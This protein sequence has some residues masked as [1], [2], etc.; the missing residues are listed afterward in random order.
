VTSPKLR[1]RGRRPAAA[2]GAVLASAAVAVACAGPAPVPARVLSNYE[3]ATGAAIIRDCGYSSPLPGQPGSSLWLFCDTETDRDGKITGLILGRDTAAAGPYQPGRVPV[4]LSEVPTPPAPAA[5]PGA[6]APQPFLPAPS[7]LLAPDGIQPCAG[8]GRYPA[9]WISGVAPAPADGGPAGLLITYDDYCVTRHPG[10]LTPEGFGLVE[11]DPRAN[12]LGP[13][14]LVFSSL[15]GQPLPPQ[16]V[17]GSP[18]VAG[19]Y[20]YLFGFCPVASLAAGCGSVLLVRVADQPA[21]WTNPF[22]YQYWTGQDWSLDQ[23]AAGPLFPAGSPLGITVGDY[24]AVG[25]GLVLVEQTSLAGDFQAWQASS[26]AGPWRRILAG[27]VPCRQGA[28]R[29]TAGLCRAIIGHPELS[30]RRRLVVSFYDPGNAHVD[31]ASFAW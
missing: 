7:G 12:L 14:S 29:G 2:L 5:P 10:V 28:Q 19:G 27:R 25:R 9:A 16:R 21:A 17:L 3:R 6:G 4:R 23:A 15:P 30:T 22:A 8:R 11:Y 13:P 26:P 18:V 20:L 1:T 31:G 24:A